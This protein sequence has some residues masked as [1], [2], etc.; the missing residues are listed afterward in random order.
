M[1][2]EEIQ[3]DTQ[4]LR[5]ALLASAARQREELKAKQQSGQQIVGPWAPLIEAVRPKPKRRRRKSSTAIPLRVVAR[6]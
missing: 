1:T 4:R 2:D 6:G 5:A 3:L